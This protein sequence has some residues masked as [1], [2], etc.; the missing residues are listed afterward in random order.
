MEPDFL[1]AGAG[2]CATS[3]LLECLREHPDVFMAPDEV[4]YFSVYHER[5]RDWYLAHFEGARPWQ[6]VGEK[7][8]TY[9]SCDEAPER[10]RREISDPTLIF[11]FRDPI[12]RAYSHYCMLLRAGKVSED[13]ESELVP[14]S[15]FVDEGL[16]FSHLQ[17]FLG[18]L[19]REQ[20]HCLFLEDLK[21]SPEDFLEQVLEII[22]VR[23]DFRP[24]LVGERFHERRP[25]PRFQK[26]Y[27]LAITFIRKIKSFSPH[28]KELIRRLRRTSIPG[29]FHAL[30]RGSS[31]PEMSEELEQSLAEY[32]R[33]DTRELSALL[34]R[35]LVSSWITPH[36]SK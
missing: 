25:R 32:Y 31:F 36:V 15:R 22:G 9:L 29:M 6:K 14:G 12:E 4:H 33:E 35:D 8:P 7:S 16:Y 2:K 13:I 17:R 34:E 5:G 27:N 11:V 18:T 23:R 1:I 30:N 3:W 10:I 26:L 20:I 19:S 21:E 28:A 24:D